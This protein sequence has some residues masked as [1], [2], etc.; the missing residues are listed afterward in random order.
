MFFCNQNIIQNIYFN[1]NITT[2]Q[3]TVACQS[4]CRKL[5]RSQG[6]FKGGG[7]GGGGGGKGREGD[8]LGVEGRRGGTLQKV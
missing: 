4:C 7:G 6:R 2:S 3:V 8:Q 5:E 1:S